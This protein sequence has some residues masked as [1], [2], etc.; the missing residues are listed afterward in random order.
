MI[1]VSLSFPFAL[2]GQQN[3]DDTSFFPFLLRCE[4]R[5]G[6]DFRN[7]MAQTKVHLVLFVLLLVPRN[8]QTLR[9]INIV[10][11]QNDVIKCHKPA[12]I[13]DTYTVPVL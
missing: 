2:N 8:Y 7:F 9:N 10:K 3:E 1:I 13:T 6:E 5:K 4:E 12:T 11:P